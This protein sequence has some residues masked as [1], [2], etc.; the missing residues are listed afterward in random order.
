[1]IQLRTMRR[2]VRKMLAAVAALGLV[3]CGGAIEPEESTH[4]PGELPRLFCEGAL[5]CPADAPIVQEAWVMLVN[6]ESTWDGCLEV[7]EEYR[8]SMPDDAVSYVTSLL[9]ADPCL[10]DGLDGP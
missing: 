2:A 5:S 3:A 10:W 9:R 8:D 4:D 1:M 7:A 6:A